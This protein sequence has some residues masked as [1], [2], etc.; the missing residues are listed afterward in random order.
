MQ[1]FG[2]AL[3]KLQGEVFTHSKEN[4]F[5]G[6]VSNIAGTFFSFICTARSNWEICIQ[7]IFHHSNS[8]E[9]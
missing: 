9:C 6:K 7:K 3:A 2:Q 8:S 1:T 5:Y 4:G